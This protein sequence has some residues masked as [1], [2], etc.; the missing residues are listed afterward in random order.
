MGLHVEQFRTGGDRNFG[1]LSVDEATGE[2]F[3]VDPSNSP[4]MLAEYAAGRGWRVRYA[5]STHGHQDHCN[6]NDEFER[7]TGT[8]VLLFGDRC[9]LTGTTVSDGARFPLGA[10]SL[11]VIHTPGHTEDSICIFSGDALFTGD[12]LFVGK[13]GGTWSDEDARQEF[14][15]LHERIMCLPEGTRVWPGHDYGTSPVSTVGHEKRTNPFLLQA[16]AAAFIELKRN[17]AAYKKTHGIA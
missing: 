17:W 5:F 9:P 8:T 7:L 16:D 1:Y 10:S 15:S 13:V 12:T 11:S 14:R 4:G 2:A 3:A 6:G